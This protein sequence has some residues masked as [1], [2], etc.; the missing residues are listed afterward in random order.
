MTDKK[1]LSKKKI[2]K[3][4]KKIIKK[5][6][7]KQIERISLVKKQKKKATNTIVANKKDK[8]IIFLILLAIAVAAGGVTFGVYSHKK[9][10]RCQE[11]M[12]MMQEARAVRRQKERSQKERYLQAVRQRLQTA[13]GLQEAWEDLWLEEIELTSE[14]Q[15]T[16]ATI[17]SCLISADDP[18]LVKLREQFRAFRK[19]TVVIFMSFL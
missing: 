10:V 4:K 19:V 15:D 8:L 17:E 2:K 1:P 3:I 14:N 11:A 13:Q 18:T 9:K 7:E 16:F 5:K 6:P 12:Q